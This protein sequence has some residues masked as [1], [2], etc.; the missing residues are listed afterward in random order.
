M[1]RGFFVPGNTVNEFF[2]VLENVR[3]RTLKYM[4]T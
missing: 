1:L 4:K 2:K 3:T